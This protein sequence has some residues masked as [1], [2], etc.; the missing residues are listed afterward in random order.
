[1]PDDPDDA[2]QIRKDGSRFL[3]LAAIG[4]TVGLIAAVLAFSKEPPK[5]LT[6]EPEHRAIPKEMVE[7]AMRRAE[8]RPEEAELTPEVTV[9]PDAAV[10]PAPTKSGAAPAL[11]TTGV[12]KLTLE[13]TPALDVFEAAKS[14]GRTPLTIT[15]R[16]GKH[17]LRFTDKE[18][19]INTYRNY[20]IIGGAE[21]KDQF[22]LGKSELRLEAPNG[23]TVRLNG[24][25]LGRAPLDPQTLYEG[26]Y[27]VEVTT[28]DNKVWSDRFDAPS[29]GTISL[30]VNF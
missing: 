16:A 26:N 3:L 10:A 22:V 12:G 29:G 11:P 2:K 27:I 8:H 5:G 24:R 20:K 14:L 18:K 25:T 19:L 1:M 23:S 6:D 28:Q 21:Q 7:E 4:L 15:L 17:Q 30:K 9:A 13:T